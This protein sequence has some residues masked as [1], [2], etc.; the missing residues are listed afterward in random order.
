MDDEC[1]KI[2]LD[3]LSNTYPDHHLLI[4]ADTC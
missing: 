2:F 4:P 3:E 1:L